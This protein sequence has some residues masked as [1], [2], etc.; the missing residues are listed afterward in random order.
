[1]PGYSQSMSIPSK[2]P[3]ATPS[4]PACVGQ[5]PVGRLPLMIRS[6]QEETNAARAADVEATS[7]KYF[8]SVHPPIDITTF[9][10]G[11]AALSLTSWL[12]FPNR[13]WSGFDGSSATPSTL[14]SPLHV[15]A[16]KSDQTS[17]S[18]QVPSV[19]GIAN[20]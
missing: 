8:D 6:M 20:A 10:F 19:A 4:P 5:P 14:V 3:A 13:C 7:E 17:L 2:R 18:V 9:R 15:G 1:M 11:C 12:K 16:W